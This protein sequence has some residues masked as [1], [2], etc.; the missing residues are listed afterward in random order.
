MEIKSV[1]ETW[2]GRTG[3]FTDDFAREYTRTF[4]V[5]TD[6]ST[7]AAIYVAYAPGIPRL[8]DSYVSFG[9]GEVDVYALC[10][11][12]RPE[13]NP[14]DPKV[15]EVT[16]DY[17]TRPG[18]SPETPTGT[19][20]T[21]PGGAGAADDAT[22][23]PPAWRWG[24]ET[25]RLPLRKGFDNPAIGDPNRNVPVINSAGLP[26][27]PLPEYDVPFR[28]L[29]YERYKTDFDAK[30]T[31]KWLH[32]INRDEFLGWPVNSVQCVQYDGQPEWFGATRLYL[33]KFKFRF[34][35]PDAKLKLQPEVLDAGQY[36]KRGDGALPG[37]PIIDP[38]TKA[39]VSR[40]WPLDG[41]GVPLAQAAVAAG[42]AVWLTFYAYKLKDFAG[43]G[44]TL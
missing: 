40:D 43:L 27:D 41:A 31:A 15:W 32:A 36:K 14:I 34:L 38:V 28:T 33:V 1:A 42:G 29:E 20:P 7:M 9:T 13:Q 39:P 3:S 23:R 35:D 30:E 22:L 44:I 19:D 24:H 21:K 37:D 26:F 10:R 6:D 16:C 8:Y 2:A 25:V 11:S 12:V 4:R 17:A 18:G 5:R